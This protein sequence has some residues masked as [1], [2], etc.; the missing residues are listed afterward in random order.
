LELAT[1]AKGNDEEGYRAEFIGLVKQA[2]L[3]SEQI[4]KQN[5]D[6]SPTQKP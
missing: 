6:D 1:E 3:I 2:K 4:V 5:T